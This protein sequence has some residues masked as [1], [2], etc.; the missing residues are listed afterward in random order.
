MCCWC[1][2]GP[3][4][5]SPVYIDNVNIYLQRLLTCCIALQLSQLILYNCWSVG[6]RKVCANW[7]KIIIRI[8]QNKRNEIL[9]YSFGFASRS[10]S[11]FT[12]DSFPF[13]F[14]V[15]FCRHFRALRT[16][17][18]F[19]QKIYFSWGKKD[20]SWNFKESSLFSQC[21]N[22]QLAF[23]NLQFTG[24]NLHLQ[25]AWSAEAAKWKTSSNGCR[26]KVSSSAARLH[27]SWKVEQ[28]SVYVVCE[29]AIW[30]KVYTYYIRLMRESW[31]KADNNNGRSVYYFLFQYSFHS[32]FFKMKKKIPEVL[33]FVF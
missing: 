6:S 23:K 17:F 15:F 14:V 27:L 5:G 4:L 11:Y 18:I 28:C 26:S 8:K 16:A 22:L 25:S 21:L 29:M 10:I 24:Y 1:G 9:F 13:W 32:N 33:V 19:E 12:I 7:K 3:F 2:G 31:P 30:K 20:K